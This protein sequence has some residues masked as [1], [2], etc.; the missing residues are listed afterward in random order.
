M[1]LAPEAV[2][3]GNIPSFY[4]KEI[5]GRYLLTND[6]GDYCFLTPPA[7]NAYLC[8]DIQS[9]FPEI[10]SELKDKGFIRSAVDS[11]EFARQYAQRY[12]PGYGPSLHIVVVTL[13]CDHNC[14]YCHAGSAGLEARDLD[15][16]I[17]TAQSTVDRIFESPSPYITIEFQGGEPLVN[18]DTVKFI[19]EYARQKNNQAKKALEFTIVSNLTFMDK[20]ILRYLIDRDIHICTSLDGPA[21]IH[22]KQRVSAGKNNTYKNTIEWFKALQREYKK[23]EYSV[24]PSALTTVTRS[25]LAHPRA[26]V[27]EYVKLGLDGIHLRP[28][29][30]FGHGRKAWKMLNFSA[31]EF[32]EFYAKA[33]NYIVEL[34]AQ[35]KFFFERFALIFLTKI[36]AK[37]EPNYLDIRSPCGAG[38]GQLAYNYNGDVYTCDEARMLG[39]AGDESFK[40][41]NA[42]KNTFGE[43]IAHEAVRAVCVSSCLENLPGC[44][45]CVYKPYCGVCP[46]SQYKE[47]GD[48]S[49]RANFLC[50]INK[51]ILDYLFGHLEGNGKAKDVFYNWVRM[52]GGIS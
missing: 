30:S 44:S 37:K 45:D 7:F 12:N 21:I 14:I 6:I 32:L 51:G 16:D 17:A 52:K 36:I 39:R 42:G 15:M 4:F 34:N 48:I 19:V 2:N 3:T 23:R 41:G 1:L 46:V 50:A 31:K 47:R 9:V 13:R 11:E 22:N 10:Y 27:D 40:L 20:K 8:G 24:L 5:S 35:G 38:I 43:L 25:S 29:S 33:V 18:W 49:G 28:V 26:I